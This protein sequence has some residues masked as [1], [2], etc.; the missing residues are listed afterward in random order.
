MK[1]ALVHDYLKDRDGIKTES[2][3]EGKD[4]HIE[5]QPLFGRSPKKSKR[6][7]TR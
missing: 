5:I 3:G 2:Y 7:L 1:I 4:R 6:R